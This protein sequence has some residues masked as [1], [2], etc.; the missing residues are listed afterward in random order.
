MQPQ[1]RSEDDPERALSAEPE[2]MKR[3]SDG[4][5][6]ARPRGRE[7]AVGQHDSKALDHVLDAAVAT[8]LLAR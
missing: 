2:L 6:W 5:A 8:R 7:G 4:G 3:R 1:I